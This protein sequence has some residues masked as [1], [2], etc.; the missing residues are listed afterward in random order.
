MFVQPGRKESNLHT[1]ASK[2][3]GLPLADTRVSF[4]KRVPCRSRTDLTGLEVQDLCRSANGTFEKAPAV[5][6]EPTLISLT[7]RRLT[8][9]ATPEYSVRM[10][11]FEPTI[12]CS[13][14]TRSSQAFPHPDK[15]RASSENRTRNSSLARRW[16]TTTPWTPFVGSTKL[17]QIKSTATNAM[18]RCPESNSRNRF[19]KTASFH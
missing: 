8:K 6:F 3:A 5:G 10:V 12:S 14:S 18:R 7:G 16:V 17:S 4:V 2:A 13:R 11:G 1:T 15:R 9:L 19:T